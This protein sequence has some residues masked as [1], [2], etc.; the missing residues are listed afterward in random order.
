[1]GQIRRAPRRRKWTTVERAIVEDKRLSYKARG[2]LIWILAKPDDWTIDGRAIA[3]HGSEGRDSCYAGLKELEIVG[4]L[5]RRRSQD[6]TT[7]RW[8]TESVVHECPIEAP[9]PDFQDPVDQDPGT[10][11]P[12]TQDPVDRESVDQESSTKDSDQRLLLTPLTPQGD[13]QSSVCGQCAGSSWIPDDT[14]TVGP[15]V[16]L[17]CPACNPLAASTQ[18]SVL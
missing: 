12:G 10:Q 5:E 18:E 8:S 3:N 14:E 2:I 6:P 17:P 4:Y 13:E 7:G 15:G 1:M 16:V 9:N 11:D